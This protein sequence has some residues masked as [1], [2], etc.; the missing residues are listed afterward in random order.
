MR[1]EAKH[2]SKSFGG[3]KAVD[4]VSLI[5]DEGTILGVIGP[6]GAGKSTLFN[7]MSG[8]DPFETGTVSIDN[9]VLSS[10]NVRAFL[11]AGIA[12]TFQ[13]TSLFDG[14]TVREN[15]EIAASSSR[16]TRFLST[17]LGVLKKDAQQQDAFELVQNLIRKFDLIE[18]ADTKCAA[19][20]AGH[21]RIVEVVRTCA[22]KPS[23]V[24]LD[25]PAAGLNPTETNELMKIILKIKNDNTAVIVVEHDLK[26]IM[27][28][29]DNVIVLDRG[30]KIA[31][32]PP[33]IVQKDPAVIASYLGTATSHERETL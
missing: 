16:G 20:S 28:L 10:G 17:I 23:I 13:N 30:Q 6:N 19:L 25:E 8:F 12:R 26:L 2:I 21:R 5:L 14:L 9:E 33:H 27:E 15:L 31:E 3:L 22:L 24:F 7:C 29:C 4:N 18:L 1:F 32:G 11:D